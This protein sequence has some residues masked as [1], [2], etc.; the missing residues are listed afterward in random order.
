MPGVASVDLDKQRLFVKVNLEVVR[1]FERLNREVEA[2]AVAGQ[3]VDPA[4]QV[5][6]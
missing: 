5:V 6:A 3:T 4:D 2:G 1:C